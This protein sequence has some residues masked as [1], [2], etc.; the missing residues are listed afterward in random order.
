M[1]GPIA[2][3]TAGRI[4]GTL[5]DGIATFKGVPYA[6]PPVGTLRF[7]PPQPPEPWTDVRETREYGPSCPQPPDRPMGWN[8]EPSVDEDC[9]YLNVWTPAIDDRERPVMVWIH[10]GGYAIGSGSW[11][12]YDGTKLARRGD[13]VVVTVNHRLGPLGYLHLADALGEEFAT[14][15]NNGQLDLIC[16]LEWVRDNI[17]SFGGDPGNVTIFGQSGG[18][19]KVTTLMA[20]P[21]AR[22]L[23]HKAV[24]MSGS[25]IATSTRE[26][27]KQLATLV[28]KELAL[29]SADVA[30][31]HTVSMNALLEAGMAAQQKQSPFRFPPPGVPP[32]LSLG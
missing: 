1:P 2:E 32:V 6:A 9:L 30:K 15:G 20:M 13:V 7:R 5:T 4:E 24:A 3:T 19:G 29:G 17:A 23:F 26:S 28:M 18:G 22:G 8:G 14:S 10:G 11:P 12:L 27:A 21:A 16:A 25:F 31:L